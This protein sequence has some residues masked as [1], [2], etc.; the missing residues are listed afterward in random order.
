M[1]QSEK[2]RY[3]SMQQQVLPFDFWKEEE[4]EKKAEIERLPY[5]PEP[6]N[7]NERLFNLQRDY[8]SG[9]EKVLTQMFAILNQVAP[10]LINIEMNRKAQKRRYF[11]QEVI[12]EMAMDAVCLFIKQI[13]KN[14]LVITRS[15]VSYLRLQVLKVMNTQT[16]AQKFEKYC[17]RHGINLFYLSEEE[18]AAIKL[19]FEEWLA[20]G[21]PEDI[22]GTK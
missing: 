8:Y 21:E 11:P 14:N 17:R 3:M 15:F 10:K 22:G 4:A 2:E 16:K 20:E 5:Y 12:D 7:D 19:R 6:K 1:T 18:K 13:K 9:N